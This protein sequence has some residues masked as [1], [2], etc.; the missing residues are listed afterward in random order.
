MSPQE[1]PKPKI[2]HFSWLG[3]RSL[4]ESEEGLNTSLVAATGK[5][6]PNTCRRLAGAVVK[7]FKDALRTFVDNV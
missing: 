3:T 7:G 5:L 2:E 6:W 4:A 1:N